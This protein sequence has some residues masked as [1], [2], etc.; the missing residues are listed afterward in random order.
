MKP[1]TPRRWDA[2]LQPERTAL[3]WQRC[4]LSLLGCAVALAAIDKRAVHLEWLL[5]TLLVVALAVWIITFGQRRYRRA[6]L[7][8]TGSRAGHLPDGTVPALTAAG[9]TLLGLV[10]LATW[11]FA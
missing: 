9:A 8:L 6:H 11:A 7:T 2:G 5:P 10:A 1:E 3:A 4:G